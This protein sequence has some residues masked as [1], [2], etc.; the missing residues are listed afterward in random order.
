MGTSRILKLRIRALQVLDLEDEVALVNLCY[1]RNDINP[2]IPWGQVTSSDPDHCALN[3]CCMRN[4]VK[5]LHF[6][7]DAGRI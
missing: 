1:K 6:S 2:L 5:F 4:H 3:L 7:W